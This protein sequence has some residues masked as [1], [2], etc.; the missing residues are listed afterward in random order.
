MASLGAT[1]TLQTK[2]GCVSPLLYAQP[3]VSSPFRHH[4]CPLELLDAEHLLQTAAD[5]QKACTKACIT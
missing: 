3:C 1:F 2:T 4:H 5:N